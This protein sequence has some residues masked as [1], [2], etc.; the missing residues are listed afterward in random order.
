MNGGM[1]GDDPDNLVTENQE[2]L[3]LDFEQL[4][5]GPLRDKV[6]WITEMEWAMGAAEHVAHGSHQAVRTRYCKGRHTL[7]R[8]EYEA[9]L[10]DGKGS[11]K[12]RQQHKRV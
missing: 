6:E 9:I 7:S 2:L 4:A 5:A 1:P 3:H 10:V 12:W 11:M 8:T